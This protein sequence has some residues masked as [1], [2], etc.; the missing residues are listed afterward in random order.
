MAK[1]AEEIAAEEAA[2][3]EAEAAA[4]EAEAEAAAAGEGEPDKMFDAAYVKKLRDEA[5]KHR[6]EARDAQAKVKQ[7]EDAN[8]SESEQLTERATTAEQQAAAATQE[9]ARVKVALKKGLTEAQAKRLV[10]TT[11]EELEADADELL[12]TFK[13]A[14][15]ADGE[16]DSPTTPRERLKPGAVPASKLEETDPAKLAAAIAKPYQ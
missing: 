14:E 1:T 8:K 9:L 2:A 4:A 5:A 6:R 10:G 16:Q 7:Y 11:E 3:A 15:D 12:E 13:P